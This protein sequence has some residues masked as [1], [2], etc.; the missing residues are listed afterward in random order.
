MDAVEIYAG[1]YCGVL[2]WRTV[3]VK[4]V[5]ASVQQGHLYKLLADFILIYELLFPMTYSIFISYIYLFWEYIFSGMRLNK[6]KNPERDTEDFL[7]LLSLLANA[8]FVCITWA[9]QNFCWACL[10]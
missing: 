7:H 3:C 2:W 10:F 1:F 5:G 8:K 4:E 6:K 9:F